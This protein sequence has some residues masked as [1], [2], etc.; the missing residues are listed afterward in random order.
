MSAWLVRQEGSPSAVS[1][2]SAAEVLAGLR[3]GNWLPTDEVK[4]PA[5]AVWQPIE[6][7]PT[8]TA[9][10][11]DIE[12]PKPEAKD[13]THLDMNPLIDVCLVLLIFFI[14]TITY[15]SLERAID[16]PD[17]SS[18]QK[19][20]TQ[21]N[22]KDVR[23]RVFIVTA[24]MDGERPVVRIEKKE[25]PLDQIALEMKQVIE[26][27]GRKEMVLDMEK[28]VPWGVETAILDAAKGNGVRQII[29]NYKRR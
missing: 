29:N 10:A 7:H 25:V 1:V 28:D 12:P 23:D 13:E 2:P 22:I 17:D 11:A 19:G 15:A 21:M 16:I 5:D 26:S 9:A 27:T 4:G 20:P 18:D 24:K 3:D 6:A 8:F 14:L